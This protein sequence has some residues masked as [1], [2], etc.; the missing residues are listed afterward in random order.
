MKN[1]KNGAFIF[2]PFL[3]LA[4]FLLLYWFGNRVGGE[5]Q[6]VILHITAIMP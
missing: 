5:K 6:E 1:K 2:L 4:A 3:F